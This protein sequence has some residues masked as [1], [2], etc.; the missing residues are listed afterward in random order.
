[1]PDLAAMAAALESDAVP[2]MREICALTDESARPWHRHP[3]YGE[4]P[5]LA[6][7]G[8]GWRRSYPDFATEA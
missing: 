7:R 4:G 5:R 1:L 8:E 2:Y 3:T 6:A